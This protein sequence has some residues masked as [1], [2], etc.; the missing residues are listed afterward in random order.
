M[1]SI[2]LIE[3]DELFRGALADALTERGFTVTQAADGAQG[4][5][6]FY[7]EPTD[8]VLTDI[9]MPNKDGTAAVA[10]LRRDFPSFGIIAMSGGAANNPAL[11][12]KI[13]GALGANRT[14]KKPFSLPMLLA[15][16]EEVLAAGSD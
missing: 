3:D 5:K 2:L 11:Y 4:V 10:D 9:V 16:M 6:L 1:S 8:L 14:L 7:A 12:L 13:A 15:T